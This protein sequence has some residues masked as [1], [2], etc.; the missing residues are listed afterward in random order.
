VR[1][2]RTLPCTLTHTLTRTLT[3]HTLTLTRTLTLTLTL[4]PSV[5]VGRDGK[6]KEKKDR[7][8]IIEKILAHVRDDKKGPSQQPRPN[9]FV[10]SLL[11]AT[12]RRPCVLHTSP[13]TPRARARR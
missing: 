5:Q 9:G 8:E 13:F 10:H 2:R 3:T 12:A 1:R 6:A 11:G 4:I 7:L